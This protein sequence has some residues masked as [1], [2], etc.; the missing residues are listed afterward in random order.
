MSICVSIRQSFRL[1]ARA[2]R[3]RGQPGHLQATLEAAAQVYC[4]CTGCHQS[5][6]AAYVR[7]LTPQS[8]LDW[9]ADLDTS[10]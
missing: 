9:V 1:L 3:I 4:K 7:S 2:L 6:L 5:E 10:L 8:C